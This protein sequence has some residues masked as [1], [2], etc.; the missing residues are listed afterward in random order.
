MYVPYDRIFIPRF[1]TFSHIP[2]PPPS[3]FAYVEYTCGL[4][5][6]VYTHICTQGLTKLKTLDLAKII[7]HHAI[8]S[9]TFYQTRQTLFADEL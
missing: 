5:M 1:Q 8:K 6:P 9:F 2:L 3:Y 4:Q 7:I